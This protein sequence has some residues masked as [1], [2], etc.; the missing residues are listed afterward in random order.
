MHAN[1]YQPPT[2]ISDPVVVEASID[3][4]CDGISH[5]SFL[6][7]RR[8]VCCFGLT[9]FFLFAAVSFEVFLSMSMI[10]GTVSLI[11]P[12]GLLVA[13]V[14]FMSWR[15]LA[16]TEFTR[17]N[18]WDTCAKFRGLCLCWG[19]TVFA[20]GLIQFVWVPERFTMIFVACLF[21]GPLLFGCAF[22]WPR[23]VERR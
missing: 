17:K 15:T 10:E 21:G 11:A 12:V 22:L 9:M 1:P 16:D 8:A 5:E 2:G 19:P 18:Y 4:D 14:Q 23:A 7:Y 6:R 13:L 20:V 3:P